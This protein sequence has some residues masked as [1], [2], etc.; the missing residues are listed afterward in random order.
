MDCFRVGGLDQRKTEEEEE[1]IDNEVYLIL[2]HLR[3]TS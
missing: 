1:R 2:S 3:S